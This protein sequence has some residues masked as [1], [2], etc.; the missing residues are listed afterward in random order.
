MSVSHVYRLSESNHGDARR[1]AERHAERIAPY[2]LDDSELLARQRR[3]ES[4]A[5]SYPPR[6]RAQ[7]I[8]AVIEIVRQALAAAEGAV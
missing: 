1:L 4:N 8:D 5:R 3:T 2:A 7:E 6:Q